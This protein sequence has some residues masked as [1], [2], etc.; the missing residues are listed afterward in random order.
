MHS[1]GPLAGST[2]ISYNQFSHLPASSFEFG[3]EGYAG[4][5]NYGGELLQITAPSDHSHHSGLVFARG[6]YSKSLYAFLARVHYRWP[7][8]EYSL[9]Q[10][11]PSKDEEQEVGV[12]AVASFV[13]D[14][15]F[16]SD[17]ARRGGVTRPTSRNCPWEAKSPPTIGGPVW[18]NSLGSDDRSAEEDAEAESKLVEDQSSGSCFRAWDGVRNIGLEAVVYQVDAAGASEGPLPMTPKESS[19]R[20][21]KGVWQEVPRPLRHILRDPRDCDSR[22]QKEGHSHGSGQTIQQGRHSNCPRNRAGLAYSADLRRHF[23]AHW[24]QRVI[25]TC[26]WQPVR[27][28]FFFFHATANCFTRMLPSAISLSVRSPQPPLL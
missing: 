24:S 3:H 23:R 4:C 19:Q 20:A 10:I 1:D 8:V 26:N 7:V 9:V 6:V 12:C 14:G 11:G 13:K 25:R 21:W 15:V 2:Y 5:W 28:Q 27:N 17:L 22:H 18:F 16:L